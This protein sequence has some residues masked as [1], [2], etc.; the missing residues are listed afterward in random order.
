MDRENNKVVELKSKNI[1]IITT[2]LTILSVIFLIL[3]VLLFFIF[4]FNK[5]YFNFSGKIDVKLAADFGTF[6]QG[7]IGTLAGITSAL[8]MIVIFLLQT[9]QSRISQV[10]NAYFKMLDY[11]RENVNSIHISDFRMEKKNKV[12]GEVFTYD[13]K[14]AF[15][16]F[17]LQLFECLDYVDNVLKNE[18]LSLTPQQKIDVA[19]MIF[20]YGFE[21]EYDDFCKTVFRKYPKDFV[22]KLFANRNIYKKGHKIVRTN[23]TSLSAYFRNLYNAIIFIDQNQDLSQEQKKNYIKILRAQ[24]SNPEQCLLYF[25]VMSRFGK[26]WKE[27]N[28]IQKYEL[29]KNI[30]R[31]YCNGFDFRSDFKINYEDDELDLGE[32]I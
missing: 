13:G 2:F 17:K 23:Q 30:P 16:I 10:E 21:R 4:I 24:L 20:Y 29:I 18:K 28:L 27:Y 8:F 32:N 5:T 25:N 12:T 31:D 7:L 6:F 11:H 15:V 14:R 26:K 22:N 3:T 9:K 19:Y 1:N